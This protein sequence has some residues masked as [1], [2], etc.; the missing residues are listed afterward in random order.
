M[1]CAPVMTIGDARI[2]LSVLCQSGLR[3]RTRG[4]SS[5]ILC[6]LT[7]R[8]AQEVLKHARSIGIRNIRWRYRKSA[9]KEKG[10]FKLVL[11]FSGDRGQKVI[12]S[13]YDYLRLLQ[14]IHHPNANQKIAQELNRS[15]QYV[16][17]YNR[18]S[19]REE[20]VKKWYFQLSPDCSLGMYTF[21]KR[22]R[23]LSEDQLRNMGIL[24]D[25]EKKPVDKTI[26]AWV[27]KWQLEY[28]F[29]ELVHRTDEKSGATTT[30][31]QAAFV[32]DN[33]KSLVKYPGSLI[34]MISDSH[35]CKK[36]PKL[37]RYERRCA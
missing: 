36:F 6:S 35:E 34:I 4:L 7:D 14:L 26:Y 12:A 11:K 13:V 19:S 8:I 33:H 37:E 32:I 31:E 18:P 16:H 17:I 28:Q 24:A 30:T 22:L 21:W 2:D 29:R 1:K 15:K 20:R 25:E 9:R 27:R 10:S 23:V 5:E 3:L